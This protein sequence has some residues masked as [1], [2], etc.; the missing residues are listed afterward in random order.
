M[1]AAYLAVRMIFLYPF[2]A[3]LASQGVGAHDA[4]A[5]TFV[6]QIDNVA[7]LIVGLLGYAATFVSSRLAK[8]KG[9][10]V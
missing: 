9:G 4:E 3:W 8:K 7:Q 10:A 2:F 1:S 6:I 5:G